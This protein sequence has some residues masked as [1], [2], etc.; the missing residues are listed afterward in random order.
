[1]VDAQPK[2]PCDHLAAETARQRDPCLLRGAVEG[3]SRVEESE[4]VDERAVE[5]L[6]RDGSLWVRRRRRLRGRQLR[7]RGRERALREG[8]VGMERRRSG[9]EDPLPRHELDLRLG[10]GVHRPSGERGRREDERR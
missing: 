1:M 9:R 8:I 7:E 3:V 10:P 5:L 6:E 4:R 2:E